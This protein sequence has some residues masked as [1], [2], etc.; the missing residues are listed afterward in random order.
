M[1]RAPIICSQKYRF[2]N[3]SLIKV[4]NKKDYFL[5]PYLVA[6]EDLLPFLTY[7][8]SSKKN[9]EILVPGVLYTHMRHFLIILLIHPWLCFFHIPVQQQVWCGPTDRFWGDLPLCITPFTVDPCVLASLLVMCG[10]LLGALSE[11]LWGGEGLWVRGTAPLSS[12]SSEF[13]HWGRRR[14][15]VKMGAYSPGFL[16]VNWPH[17]HLCLTVNPPYK[18]LFFQVLVMHPCFHSIR[19]RDGTSLAPVSPRLLNYSF[20]S[21]ISCLHFEN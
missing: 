12:V 9:S 19:P 6:S 21:L 5:S 15:A 14:E 10:W 2:K 18:S 11:M 4:T 3:P 16:P 13:C 17:T 7:Y 8:N 1:S 20:F